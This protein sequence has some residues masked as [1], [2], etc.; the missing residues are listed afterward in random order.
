[1]IRA[2]HPLLE[3]AEHA[4]ARQPLRIV[5]GLVSAYMAIHWPSISKSAVCGPGSR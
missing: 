1:M 2:D 4:F 3:V 5:K